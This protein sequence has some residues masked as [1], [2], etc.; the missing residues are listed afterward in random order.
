MGEA[1]AHASDLNRYAVFA[2]MS[3]NER[4]RLCNFAFSFNNF[5]V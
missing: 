2:G 5:L 4:V 3:C 1:L